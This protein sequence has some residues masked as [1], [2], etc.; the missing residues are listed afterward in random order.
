MYGEGGSTAAMS[1]SPLA[2]SSTPPTPPTPA[3][4][5]ASVYAAVTALQSLDNTATWRSIDVMATNNWV[6]ADSLIVA[7]FV[8]TIRNEWPHQGPTNA[9]ITALVRF[10]QER[11]DGIMDIGEYLGEAMVRAAA[12]REYDALAAIP[13][14]VQMTFMLTVI[15]T[16]TL[17]RDY[18]GE[19]LR[20]YVVGVY[21]ATNSAKRP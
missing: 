12:R 17:R 18:T 9:Q 2:G 4:V 11:F 6:D 19:R 14:D 1:E 20:D 13:M 15:A 7:L 3:G 21:A 5:A 16:I 10:L 8:R